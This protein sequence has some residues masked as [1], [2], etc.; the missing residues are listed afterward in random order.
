MN[1]PAALPAEDEIARRI[2]QLEK[3][4]AQYG[5]PYRITRFDKSHSASAV[6]EQFAH[7]TNG[8]KT[9]QSVSV[10]GRIMAIRNDGMFIV[11]LDDTDRL[12]IFHDLKQISP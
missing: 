11:I 3:I 6:K 9:T 8:E 10:A 2:T 7:L 4:T 12:Q 1:Q 5:D